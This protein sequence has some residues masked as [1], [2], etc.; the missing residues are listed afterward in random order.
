[1]K[2][3]HIFLVTIL[4]TLTVYNGFSQSAE[5]G[6]ASFYNDKFENSDDYPYPC[7][8]GYK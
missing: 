6:M 3:K 5:T 8:S 2:T 4:L 7:L 1:M